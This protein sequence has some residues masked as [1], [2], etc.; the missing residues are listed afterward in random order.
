MCA[1][2]IRAWMS[3]GHAVSRVFVGDPEPMRHDYWRALCADGVAITAVVFPVD[4]ASIERLMG[5]DSRKPDILVCHA[6]MRRIPASILQRHRHGGVNFHPSLLPHFRGPNP[7]K[8]MIAAG[9]L[10]ECAGL[11]LHVMTDEFDAGDVIA[12]APIPA[13]E[14]RDKRRLSAAITER[15]CKMAVE[16]IPAYCRGQISARPQVGAGCESSVLPPIASIDP[17]TWSRGDIAAA[18]AFLKR[19]AD[20]QLCLEP[21]GERIRVKEVLRER[22]RRSGTPPRMSMVSVSFD[23]VDGHITMLRNNFAGKLA[24]IV[25]RAVKRRGA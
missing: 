4:W 5:A 3:A 9:R 15:M 20:L 2:L 7:T 11:S 14:Y 12:Q 10:R 6:F 19:H 22:N 17:A 16:E 25:L 13:S 24:R 8:A 18:C 21:N 1:A 23:C